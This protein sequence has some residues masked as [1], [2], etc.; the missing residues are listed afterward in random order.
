VLNASRCVWLARCGG[1]FVWLS[2]RLHYQTN[3]ALLLYTTL[4]AAAL[5]YF[6]IFTV[7]L[8]VKGA[9]AAT[10]LAQVRGAGGSLALV[11]STKK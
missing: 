3:H 2:G 9:A 11:G 7:G 6:L 10:V 5:D 4:V 1:E 8:G